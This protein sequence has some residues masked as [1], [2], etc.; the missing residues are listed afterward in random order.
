MSSPY[1]FMLYLIALPLFDGFEIEFSYRDEFGCLRCKSGALSRGTLRVHLARRF[2][3]VLPN[4][5]MY[6]GTIH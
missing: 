2:K 6:S 1:A 4:V 5:L 3:S